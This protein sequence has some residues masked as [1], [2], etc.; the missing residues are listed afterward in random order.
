MGELSEQ[1]IKYSPFPINFVLLFV[2]SFFQD[3]RLCF[4]IPYKNHRKEHFHHFTFP[5]NAG[6]NQPRSR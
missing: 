4:S 1:V 5:T 2:V 6:N 3:P